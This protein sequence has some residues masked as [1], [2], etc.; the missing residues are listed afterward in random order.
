MWNGL[1]VSFEKEIKKKKESHAYCKGAEDFRNGIT[2]SPFEADSN[3][4][5]E[6]F[7]G[8]LDAMFLRKL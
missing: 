2:K 6:W 8:F 3:A 7:N 5:E 4:D 1:M